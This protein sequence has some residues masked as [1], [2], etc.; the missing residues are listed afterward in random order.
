[1]KKKILSVLLLLMFFTMASCG[2]LMYKDRRFV[3]KSDRIDYFV[4]GIDSMGLFCFVVPG[5]VF[6]FVDYSTGALWLSKDEDSRYVEEGLEQP[7]IRDIMF[8]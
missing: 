4:L 5:L 1:M 3:E 7:L 2:S 8:D 6:L